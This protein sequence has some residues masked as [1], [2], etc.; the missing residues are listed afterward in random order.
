MGQLLTEILLLLAAAALA[1]L[2]LGWAIFHRAPAT[3]SAATPADGRLA[4]EL[5]EA[6][7]A[8]REAESRARDVESRAKEAGE[9]SR[10]LEQALE[11]A[12]AEARHLEE[13]LAAPRPPTGEDPELSRLR[14]EVAELKA[15]LASHAAPASETREGDAGLRA[16]LDQALSAQTRL[17]E[18]VAELE[19]ER[20]RNRQ[21]LAEQEATL[22]S[23][24]RELTGRGRPASPATKVV[25]GPTP[26]K[27]RTPT[28]S[29]MRAVAG[30]GATERLAVI[31]P[32]RDDSSPGISVR[33]AARTSTLSEGSPARA[34]NPRPATV[35]QSRIDPSAP[36]SPAPRSPASPA[37]ASDGLAPDEAT[38]SVSLG[39]LVAR[40]D[41]ADQP[42][43]PPDEATAALDVLSLVGRIDATTDAGEDDAPEEDAPASDGPPPFADASATIQQQRPSF[44]EG[45]DLK[46]LKG[47]GPVTELRLRE[48]GV[49]SW[50]GLADLDEASVE[51]LAD[52]M[53]MTVER[54][55]PWIDQARSLAA[56]DAHP[57]GETT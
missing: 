17:E 27:A 49:Q 57:S 55:R 48:F 33:P 51:R 44:L 15:A 19:A 5:D 12:R 26:A 14:A 11:A 31:A 30:K 40:I 3:P 2:G 41:A 45:D 6:R 25:G 29:T 52:H 18:A 37:P 53:K 4:R 9:R 36:R 28:L 7:K 56:T 43:A 38:V 24:T 22:D 10:G 35:R 54:V 23:L 42:P 8:H 21:M 39:D 50:R 13:R 20:D 32:Q 47:V 16:E 34:E 1:G 46:I